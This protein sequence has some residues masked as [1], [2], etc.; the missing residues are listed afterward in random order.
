MAYDLPLAQKLRKA[1]WKVKIRQ[2]ERLEPPHVTILFKLRAW[3]LC[4]RASRFL[5]EGDSWNQIKKDVRQ[6]IEAAWDL[7]REEWDKL[8]PHNPVL[9]SIEDD[10]DGGKEE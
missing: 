1:G 10:Q 7:L 3:R 8:Y 4:L 6:A 2:N 9:S 5:D